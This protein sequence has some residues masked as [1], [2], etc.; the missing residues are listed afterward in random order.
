MTY[1]YDY[2]GRIHGTTYPVA[3]PFGATG[4]PVGSMTFYYA[5]DGMGRPA[6][7]DDY[8]GWHWMQNVQY[9]YAGRATS[10][11][12]LAGAGVYTTESRA[13]NFSGQLN[14][15]GW[16]TASGYGP[17]GGIQYSYSATQNNGQITGVS[18]TVSGETINY[19][20][21]SLKRLTSA[22][23]TPIAGG[24]PAAWTQTFQYDGFGNLTAKVLNGS[25]SPIYVDATTN[26]LAAVTAGYD[27]NGNMTSGLTPL[28]AGVTYAYDVANRL[29]SAALVSGGAEYYAYAP[30]N[31]RIYKLKAD[32]VTE[33]WTF[34]GARGEKLGVYSLGSGG[35]TP[36]RSNVYFAGKLILDS[37][38][39][40]FLDRLGTNRSSGARFY[41]YGDEITP[42]SNDREKFGTYTRDGYT[43]LDYADQR[44][45]ASSYGRFDSSDPYQASGGP[46]DPGS[47]NRY[48]YTQSDPVNRLDKTGLFSCYVGVAFDEEDTDLDAGCGGGLEG[49]LPQYL[50]GCTPYIFA[51]GAQADAYGAALPDCENVGGYIV[52]VPPPQSGLNFASGPADC[53]AALAELTAATANV[54]RRVTEIIQYGGKPD[55]GH[56]KALSQAVNRLTNARDRVRASCLTVAAAAAAL[57][58]AEAELE[59]AAAYLAVAAAAA[60]TAPVDPDQPISVA[61][62]SR[63]APPIPDVPISGLSLISPRG[64]VAGSP[65]I[66]QLGNPLRSGISHP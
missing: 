59:A 58:A 10:I 39:A 22:A 25:T 46:G 53:G 38:N 60:V 12:F 11:Q 50:N 2:A 13:Y 51:F 20:Y 23:A 34:F 3:A 5:I 43:G 19:A 8:H 33:E 26:R 24:T 64:A 55:A 1:E 4:Y 44:F 28:G 18:D 6:T 36:L 45:Y 49:E 62:P 32:G 57:A 48:A 52:P 30:D 54:F 14:S 17:T 37:N 47:S 35:F 65:A 27:L 15:L 31:K 61:P 66:P 7:L 63:G 42:T 40:V 29:A 56:V 9:D 16:S 41:P 21:D